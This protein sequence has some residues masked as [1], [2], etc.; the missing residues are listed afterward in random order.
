[1]RP[2]L[3]TFS[4]RSQA[5]AWQLKLE[6]EGLGWGGVGGNRDRDCLRIKQRVKEG[7]DRNIALNGA[8]T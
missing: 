5:C 1:M 2:S 7:R 4:Q 6:K 3:G 8:S